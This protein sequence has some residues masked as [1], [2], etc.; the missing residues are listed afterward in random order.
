MFYKISKAH[1]WIICRFMQSNEM[2]SHCKW[3]GHYAWRPMQRHSGVNTLSHHVALTCTCISEISIAWKTMYV[4]RLK[5]RRYFFPMEQILHAFIFGYCD[6]WTPN[7]W[8]CRVPSQYKFT[9]YPDMGVSIIKIKRSHDRLIYRGLNEIKVDV[10]PSVYLYQPG[11][12]TVCP[13]SMNTVFTVLCLVNKWP[14]LAIS[15]RV[16]SLPLS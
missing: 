12:S 5:I 6:D 9:A 7:M 15:F 4:F 2:C 13:S 10:M 1:R 3:Y 14:N 11:I 16:A 8:R